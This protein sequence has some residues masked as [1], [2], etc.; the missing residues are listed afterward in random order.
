MRPSMLDEVSSAMTRSTRRATP[1]SGSFLLARAGESA[2]KVERAERVSRLVLRMAGVNA[3][4]GP[5]DLCDSGRSLPARKMPLLLDPQ[6]L[7]LEDQRR[8]PRDVRRRPLV[9][10]GDRR[11]AHQL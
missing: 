11:R 8:A 1:G 3:P 6:Q 4:G 5:R 2:R 10:V 9:A 7:H